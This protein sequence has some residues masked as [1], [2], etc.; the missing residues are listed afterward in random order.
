MVCVINLSIS[1]GIYIDSNK[2][3]L[4]I[5][6]TVTVPII[7]IIVVIVLLMG[8]ISCRKKIQKSKTQKTLN[9]GDSLLP[10]SSDCH[11]TTQLQTDESQQIMR[12]KGSMSVSDEET[13]AIQQQTDEDQQN[14]SPSGSPIISNGDAMIH[15]QQTDDQQTRTR[16]QGIECRVLRFISCHTLL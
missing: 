16:P 1:P 10:F 9:F 8:G 11:T 3:S 2:L 4:V 13:M 14:R 5:G 15:Q 12:L 6:V 7:I